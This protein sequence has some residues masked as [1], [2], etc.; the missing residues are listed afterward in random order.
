M[1]EFIAVGFG[2]FIG[3]CLRFAVAKLVPA[4]V[5]PFPTLISNVIAGLV[6]GI[7]IG[8]DSHFG[9]PP[10]TKLFLTTGMMG[11]LST[12]SSFSLETVNLLGDGEYL[13]ASGNIVLNVGLSLFGVAIG[14]LIGK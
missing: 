6:I 11:G 7:I 13:L 2:G 14:I 10:R 1:L 4:N 9:I 12:F 3:A 8:L 5:F